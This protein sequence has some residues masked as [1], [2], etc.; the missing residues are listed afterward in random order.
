V[1]FRVFSFVDSANK[2]FLERKTG[3]KRGTEGLLQK[4]SYSAPNVKERER[5]IWC[6]KKRKNSLRETKKNKKSESR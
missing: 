2:A 4:K 3:E 5:E 6:E 1:I